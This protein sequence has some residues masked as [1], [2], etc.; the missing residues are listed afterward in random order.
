MLPAHSQ[1]ATRLHEALPSHREEASERGADRD[2]GREAAGERGGHG[3]GIAPA[4]G[5]L[6]ARGGLQH[7][8][9]DEGAEG[10]ATEPGQ[11]ASVHCSQSA[12]SHVAKHVQWR[13]C[14]TQRNVLLYL[15]E[16]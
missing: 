14:G 6:A 8:K 11:S 12:L 15:Q 10:V 7:V 1:S 3:P 5:G 13:I 4:G 9:R 16:I 2:E